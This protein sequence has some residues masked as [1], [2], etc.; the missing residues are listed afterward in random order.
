MVAA[1]K[2]QCSFRSTTE[3]PKKIREQQELQNKII[4]SLVDDIWKKYDKDRDGVLNQTET[5]EFINDFLQDYGLTDEE[6]EEK[7]QEMLMQLSPNSNI[8]SHSSVSSDEDKEEDDGSRNYDAI[9]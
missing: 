2:R 5:L 7:K 1:P 6:R 9:L 4:Q 3:S 8:S